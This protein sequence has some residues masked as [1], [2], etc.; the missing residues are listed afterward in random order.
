MEKEAVPSPACTPGFRELT[1]SLTT[2]TAPQ[3]DCPG[4]RQPRGPTS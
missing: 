1:A 3:K 2:L 4:L